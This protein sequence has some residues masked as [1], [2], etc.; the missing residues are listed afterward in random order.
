M[1]WDHL[2]Y[3]AVAA[4]FCWITGSVTSFFKGQKAFYWTVFLYA[5]GIVIYGSFS[6]LDIAKTTS[7][8]YHGRNPGS[9]IPCSL[10]W[11]VGSHI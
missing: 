1:T 4:A 10:H 6:F 8:G 7:A 11:P 3:F 5:A 2:I 9:G